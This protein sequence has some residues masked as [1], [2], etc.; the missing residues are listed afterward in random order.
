MRRY[1]CDHGV[2]QRQRATGELAALDK[3]NAAVATRA[4]EGDSLPKDL[5]RSTSR[6][7]RLSHEL[8]RACRVTSRILERSLDSAYSSASR[9]RQTKKDA[10]LPLP[11]P[12]K[13]PLL[14]LGRRSADLGVRPEQRLRDR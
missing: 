4:A 12:A 14:D 7:G 6:D 2:A 11:R 3:K 1:A 8:G 5:T 13:R 10:G 9:Y